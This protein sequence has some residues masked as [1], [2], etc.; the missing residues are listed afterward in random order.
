MR[1]EGNSGTI[2]IGWGGLAPKILEKQTDAGVVVGMRRPASRGQ[3]GK[4]QLSRSNPQRTHSVRPRQE[5]GFPFPIFPLLA[6]LS[7]HN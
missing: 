5:T 2:K 4:A 1:S 7:H 3:T 6:P